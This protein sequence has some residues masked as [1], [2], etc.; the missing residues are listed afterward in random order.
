MPKNSLWR[1][2]VEGPQSQKKQ[3]VQR[4]WGEKQQ[5]ML[6]KFQVFWYC[7][8]RQCVC[9]WVRGCCSVRGK[10]GGWG[11]ENWSMKEMTF[12]G[13]WQLGHAGPCTL[14]LEVWTWIYGQWHR[15]FVGRWQHQGGNPGLGISA[16]ISPIFIQ[17]LSPY[18]SYL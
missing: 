12:G 18:P 2:W 4:N 16:P 6:Q 14:L 11:R 17:H 5:K 3:Y 7:W 15:R 13:K 1:G 9:V 10:E 8:S